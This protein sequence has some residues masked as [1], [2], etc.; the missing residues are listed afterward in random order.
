MD[1]DKKIEKIK[2]TANIFF[3]FLT[4]S[5]KN[6][7]EQ[8]EK[9]KE[10]ML[11]QTHIYYDLCILTKESYKD[12]G[13]YDEL[14]KDGKLI[15]QYI[16][17]A[18]DF[19]NAKISIGKGKYFPFNSDGVIF[20]FD[21]QIKNDYSSVYPKAVQFARRYFDDSASSDNIVLVQKLMY[22]II[23]DESID[24]SQEFYINS[25]GK[26]VPKSKLKSISEIE[27][28]AFI[29]GVWHYLIASQCLQGDINSLKPIVTELLKNSND[30]KLVFKNEYTDSAEDTSSESSNKSASY[31]KIK[32]PR[33]KEPRIC[34]WIESE[35]PEIEIGE[36]IEDIY[37]HQEHDT[38]IIDIL[39]NN[40]V[41]LSRNIFFYIL[42][43]NIKTVHPKRNKHAIEKLFLSLINLTKNNGCSINFNKNFEDNCS[44]H[45]L[46]LKDKYSINFL[47]DKTC[48]TDFSKKI[49]TNYDDIL[50]DM[51][52][53]CNKFF[54]SDEYNEIIVVSI[55][56]FIRNDST[57]NDNQEFYVCSDGSALTK[58]QLCEIEEIE[59]EPFLIGIWYYVISQLDAKDCNGEQTF[60][61]VFNVKIEYR[62]EEYIRYRP[63]SLIEE[64][65]EQYVELIYLEE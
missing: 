5:M 17:H 35:I 8:F 14:L 33:T 1:D 55:I 38:N 9:C 46:D 48:I 13:E 21:H 30:I 52:N 60:D 25:N 32:R 63:T 47:D 11:T 41:V 43:D 20:A 29:L 24:D 50:F 57:I 44:D 26:A 23:N 22:Y 10:K 31:K 28:E 36:I 64:Q 59:F 62:K 18:S 49:R 12:L 15:Q 37:W 3:I 19:R 39:E 27:F 2:L 7:A 16:N 6:K 4:D 51:I 54:N 45:F 42:S 61:T 53:I 58:S 56:E 65:S 34:D 40:D